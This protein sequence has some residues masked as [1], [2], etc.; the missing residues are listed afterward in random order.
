[1]ETLGDSDNVVELGAI[2]VETRGIEPIGGPEIETGD[3]Y[4]FAGGGISAHD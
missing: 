2:S 4:V 1:M 3:Y